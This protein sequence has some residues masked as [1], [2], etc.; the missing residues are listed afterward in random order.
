MFVQPGEWKAP[1]SS[2]GSL[3]VLKE[4]SQERSGRCVEIGQG[5]MVL[6]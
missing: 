1:R 6:I 3:P 2:Y 5:I 4:G